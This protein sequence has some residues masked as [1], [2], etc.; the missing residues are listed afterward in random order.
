MA[1]FPDRV[2]LKNST[3][4]EA[5]IEAAIGSGGSDAITPGELVLGLSAGNLT[6]FSLDSN[7]DIVKFT[8]TS[9]SGRA[10][11]SGTEPTVG[12]NGQPLADGD[13]WYESGTSN[14]Y[15]YYN[16]AWV[17]LSGGGGGSGTVTSVDI[18]AGTG[19]LAAG[20][21]IT[22][23]GSISLDLDVSGVTP[24]SYTS[25]NVTV[26][27]F[28]RVTAISN[29][30]GGGYADPLTTAGDLVYRSGLGVTDR[31]GIGTAGQVLTM[32][33]GLPS[34]Q[35]LPAPPTSGTVTSVD[36]TPGT[37]IDILGG[38]ITTS[39][40][41]I[42]SLEDT[43]VTPGV[44]TSANITVDQQ[45]RITAVTS[46]A[47]GGYADPLTTEGDIVIRSGG[48]TT[49][50]GIGTAGQV[51]A[52]TG[53]LPAW[54]DNVATVSVNDLTDT[55]ITSAATGDLL[56]W[57]GS[58][59]VNYAD[60]AYANFVQGSLADSALQPTDSIGALSDVN[61]VNPVGGQVLTWV[62]AA[63][64]WQAI[65]SSTPTSR[66]TA[67]A[68]TSALADGASED[69]TITGTGRAGQLVS[70][71]TDVA[72]WVTIYATEEARTSDISRLET[73]DPSPGSGVLVEVITTTGQTILVTP[74][75]NYFN[76]ENPPE[77]E[78]YA[79]IVNKSGVSNTVTVTL[80]I[81]KTEV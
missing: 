6:I 10:I 71:T 19:L 66:A 75:V 7:N 36:L 31:L 33:S 54:E 48:T 61:V 49:R 55:A 18:T 73:E 38:P 35:D 24:G 1:V 29:G 57:N 63:N 16:S 34:W 3:D 59:W 50:L 65:D 11:V 68:T 13:L 9:A 46:G 15:V 25:A 64:N 52:V 60:S 51:L 74:S 28:G 70:I 26:D 79:K 14:Y 42:V 78:L 62:D 67:T 56:R 45:G 22:T 40:S 43:A 81:S 30:A 4:S 77:P 41:I 12:I 72:A 37:G 27:P 58:T 23:S 76:A 47:G 2:V 44:Y 21:P 39:G 69:I 20:G 32:D 5:A 53:G 8:P 17:Q 80:S